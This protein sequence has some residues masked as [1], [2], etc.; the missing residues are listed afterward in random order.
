[1]TAVALPLTLLAIALFAYVIRSGRWGVWV[2]GYI[3][4]F[5]ALATAMLEVT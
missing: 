1:L 5:L 3:F 4:A 2:A